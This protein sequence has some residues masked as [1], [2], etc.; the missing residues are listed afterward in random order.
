MFKKQQAGGKRKVC[1]R[2]D[3]VLQKLLVTLMKPFLKIA[4]LSALQT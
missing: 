3:F 4:S 1:H 2:I